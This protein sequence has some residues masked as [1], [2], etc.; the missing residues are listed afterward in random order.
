MMVQIMF[1]SQKA[2]KLNQLQKFL[3]EKILERWQV[4]FEEQQ[5]FSRQNDATPHDK[6][7][8]VAQALLTSL[9]S[10]YNQLVE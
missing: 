5:D 1:A 6:I 8:V 2:V 10:V 4:G 3:M 9:M 7:R